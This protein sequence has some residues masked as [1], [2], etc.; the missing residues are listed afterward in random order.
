MKRL[1]VLLYGVGAYGVF[2][3]TFLYAIG[4]VGNIAVPKSIDASP[5]APV[6]TA[7]LVNFVVLTLFAVQHSLMAR[8]FFKRAWT[9]I[10]NPAAE[11]STYVLFSSVALMILFYFWE[12][13]GGT[14]WRVENPVAAGFIY[15]AFA[16][17]WLLVL[18][19][20]CL[21]NH[22]DLFGLRQVWI[23]FRGREYTPVN[24]V[25]PWLYGVVRHPLYVGF[26]IAFWATPVM[27]VTHL[28]FAL[29]TTGYIL[30][31]IQFEE[32]DLA[33]EHPEY[34][35]YKRRVPMLVPGLKSQSA[36]VHPN[37]AGA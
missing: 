24:F 30:I 4:F 26:L 3:A 17:G 2:F 28:L 37:S 15:F 25:Q 13:L 5:T 20:T 21:I 31:A 9:R 12:P 35:D 32:H 11:R 22:F 34:L 27:T 33:Q 10:I 8:P 23:H 29:A 14:V 1:L 19:S 18:F 36:V 7:V 6:V 16:C